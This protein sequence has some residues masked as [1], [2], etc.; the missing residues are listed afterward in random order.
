LL[1]A[2]GL[3]MTMIALATIISLI[4]SD[5][6]S[7]TDA[8]TSALTSLSDLADDDSSSSTLGGAGPTSAAADDSSAKS[9]ARNLVT[10]I[11]S[12]FATSSDYS[13]CQTAEQLG[14]DSGDLDNV[15]ISATAS[16]YKVTA[17]SDTDN[18]FTIT[19]TASGTMT[20]TCTSADSAGTCNGG[21]W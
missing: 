3:C 12:C 20:R 10:Q 13:R 14:I 1:L 9:D 15:T 2:L 17:T 19:K 21:T 7:S 16:E 4:T 6:L 8:D 11:E 18:T 5:D